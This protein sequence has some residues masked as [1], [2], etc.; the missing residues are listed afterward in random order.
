MGPDG[1]PERSVQDD[2]GRGVASYFFYVAFLGAIN[3]VLAVPA[4]A[5][6]AAARSD[7]NVDLESD[8]YSGVGRTFAGALEP[9]AMGGWVT[10]TVVMLLVSVAAGPAY[11]FMNRQYESFYSGKD[12]AEEVP[13]GMDE[14]EEHRGYTHAERAWRRTLS[15]VATAAVVGVQGLLMWLLNRALVRVS[16]DSVTA[17]ALSGMLAVSNIVWKQVVRFLTSLEVHARRTA[18]IEWDSGKVFA[19]RICNL[20]SLYLVKNLTGQDNVLEEGCDDLV[21]KDC[22]CPLSSMAYQFMWLIIMEL[23]IN[24]A[25]EIAIPYVMVWANQAFGLTDAQGT[26]AARQDFDL[27]EEYTALLYRQSVVYLGVSVFPLMPVLAAAASFLEFWVDKYKLTALSI[28]P[29]A[30]PEPVRAELILGAH[31]IIAAVAALSYPNG[32]I[33]ILSGFAGIDINC[34]FFAS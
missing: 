31:L 30:P 10:S 15:V 21:E 16:S 18:E 3:C 32:T 25:I 20:M 2:F 4:V 17:V 1:S 7:G 23:T 19:V 8:V 34:A 13:A 33:L 27:T 28:K 6:L 22:R 14:I 9:G 29:K 24:N 11:F 5:Q 12:R 26:N